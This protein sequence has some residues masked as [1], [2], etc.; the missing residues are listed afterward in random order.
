M[1]VL[2]AY[3]ETLKAENGSL[4]RRLADA[5]A[6]AAQETAKAKRPR[7]S[8]NGAQR[9]RLSAPDPGGIGD[10]GRRLIARASSAA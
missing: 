9:G 6:L 4:K 7:L 1:R 10:G 2:E 3:N 5:E 8:R